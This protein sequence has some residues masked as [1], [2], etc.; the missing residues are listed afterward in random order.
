MYICI[1]LFIYLL[2]YLLICSFIYLLIYFGKLND[3]LYT[4]EPSFTATTLLRPRRYY[5]QFFLSWSNA[6]LLRPYDQRP[7][8]KNQT[9]YFFHKFTPLMRPVWQNA[10]VERP[11]NSKKPTKLDTQWQPLNW[12]VTCQEIHHYKNAI[13]YIK[14]DILTISK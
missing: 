7:L 8:F 9:R 10:N 13:P 12:K 5:G 6:Q 4:V 1:Y 3:I 14:M 2:I 11:L